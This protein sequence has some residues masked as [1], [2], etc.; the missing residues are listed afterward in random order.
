M[1]I[2][3][4]SCESEGEIAII[5]S[6]HLSFLPRIRHCDNN[7]IEGL[8]PSEAFY[9]KV[10]THTEL[11]ARYKIVTIHITNFLLKCYKFR[12][13]NKSTLVLSFTITE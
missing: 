10:H 9:L 6:F 8:N 13:C 3:Y 4:F 12:F 7:L 5:I 1:G 2:R 11:S